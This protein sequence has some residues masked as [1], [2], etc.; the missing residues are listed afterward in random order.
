MTAHV[1][2]ADGQVAL[3][4]P[5]DRD[6]P[7]QA[8]ALGGIWEKAR[9]RWTFPADREDDVR[10]L[11]V[12]VFGADDA[13]SVSR[14]D[15]GMV[16]PGVQRVCPNWG[17]VGEDQD[18]VEVLDVRERFV[19]GDDD[20]MG[21]PYDH[22]RTTIYYRPATANQVEEFEA[23]QVRARG[24]SEAR[25][26]LEAAQADARR[27]LHSFADPTVEADFD[28]R[29]P[30][31]TVTLE[32]VSSGSVHGVVV[33]AHIQDELVRV[34]RS[35]SVDAIAW[36]RGTGAVLAARAAALTE[37]QVA[38]GRAWLGVSRSGGATLDEATE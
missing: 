5:Y 13:L 29:R 23:E 37:A 35:G 34:E 3:T 26:D 14:V 28:L 11:V 6:F 18:V 24:E 27:A 17:I 10:A 1:Q 19:R 36:F 9:G 8:R 12:E 20:G 31:E 7:V 22:T 15:I 30:T 21:L 33:Q 2:V 16:I 25:R 32:A 38:E 4:S